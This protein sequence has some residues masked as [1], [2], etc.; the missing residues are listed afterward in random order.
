MFSDAALMDSFNLGYEQS[1]VA[2]VAEYCAARGIGTFV[3]HGGFRRFMKRCAMRELRSS[4]PALL[5]P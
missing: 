3:K 2:E 1:A 5:S 4:R